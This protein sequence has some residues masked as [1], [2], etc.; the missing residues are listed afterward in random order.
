MQIWIP[1]IAPDT[2]ATSIGKKLA[3]VYAKNAPIS[4]EVLS[5]IAA[6]TKNVSAAF[7]KELMRRATQ[8]YLEKDRSDSLSVEDIDEA[9][10]EMLF[11]GGQLNVKLL[12]GDVEGIDRE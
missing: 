4:D 5:A 7:L 1:Q 12:G 9:L 10:T 6:K 11:T 3:K 2:D 8:F